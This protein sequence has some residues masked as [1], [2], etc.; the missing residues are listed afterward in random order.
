MIGED[1][2]FIDISNKVVSEFFK[3]KY[4][5]YKFFIVD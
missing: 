1:L 5:Y 3:S 4:N 2:N